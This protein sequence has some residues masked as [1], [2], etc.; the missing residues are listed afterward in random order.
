MFKNMS[1]DGTFER[2]SAQEHGEVKAYC[3]HVKGFRSHLVYPKSITLLQVQRIEKCKS[4]YL[5][6]HFGGVS[7]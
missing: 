2:R 5:R 6:N 3:K 4:K 1:G 7:T